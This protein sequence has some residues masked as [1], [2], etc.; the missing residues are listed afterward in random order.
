MGAFLVLEEKDHALR[1]AA[2]PLAR[3]SVVTSRHTKRVA[4][5]VT[6]SLEEAWA[7]IAPRIEARAAAAISGASGAEAATSEERRFLAAHPDLPVRA[8][9]SH[10]GHGV[11]GQFTMNIALAAIALAHG[12][13]FATFDPT[14]FER[15]H[16][17]PLRQIAVTGVGHWR[18]EGLALIEAIS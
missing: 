3:I 8:T 10:L 6:R 13:L 17:A 4:G 12:R 1:R 9:G 14:G 7:D 18:G 15:A 5:G 2:K 16:D 11:E